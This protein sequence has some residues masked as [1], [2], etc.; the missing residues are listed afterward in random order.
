MEASEKI[1][2]LRELFKED[3]LYLE[4]GRRGLE[5]ELFSPCIL[6]DRVIF[7]ISYSTKQAAE[8]LEIP[9]K[10][11][12]LINFLNRNDFASY[13]MIDRK[14]N[15][16]YY[17]Y[18]Y[19]TLFQFKMILLLSDYDL[20][21]LEIATIVGIR[22]EYENDG[23]SNRR[24]NIKVL[25]PEP[26]IEEIVDERNEQFFSKMKDYVNNIGNT[27]L[28]QQQEELSKV[29]QESWERETQVL[30]DRIAD[31]ELYISIHE[32]ILNQFSSKVDESKSIWK[33]LFG[34]KTTINETEYLEHQ[35]KL[36]DLKNKLQEL[37]DQKKKKDEEKE[38]MIQLQRKTNQSNE[39]M[40]KKEEVELY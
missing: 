13:I 11:Q 2:K 4:I 34:S 20:T 31:M 25:P 14:G 3:Q 7:D 33:R 22:V 10:E 29:R 17:R 5:E 36:V 19:K 15:R 26:S 37:L 32:R 6:Y 40:K 38:R 28:K 27:L 1:E 16:R 30:V 18:D 24:G 39:L 35:I 23:R 12:T 9:G 8:L 21:P